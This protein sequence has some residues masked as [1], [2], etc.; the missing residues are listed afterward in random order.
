MNVS[1]PAFKMAM[2][3]FLDQVALQR[4]AHYGPLAKFDTPQRLAAYLTN[5]N[6]LVQNNLVKINSSPSRKYWLRSS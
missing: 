5:S 6:G 3:F 2:P 1:R 4:W